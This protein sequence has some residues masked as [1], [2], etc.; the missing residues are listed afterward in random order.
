MDING[1][2]EVLNTYIQSINHSTCKV[3]LHK[4]KENA[5]MN[6]Y[7]TYT[8]TLW[9]IVNGS[10]SIIGTITYTGREVTD[11]EEATNN[12]IMEEKLLF[13]IYD[14]LYNHNLIYNGMPDKD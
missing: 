2:V 7:K 12:K 10:K 8:W 9:I 14:I 4:T 1:I 5:V 6:A 11:T 13:Y 3:V